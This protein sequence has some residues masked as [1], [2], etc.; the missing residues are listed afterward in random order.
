MGSTGTQF[1]P[2]TAEERRELVERPLPTVRVVGGTRSWGGTSATCW[3][4]EGKGRAYTPNTLETY[5][6]QQTVNVR[7]I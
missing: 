5:Q 6:W 3:F 1:V 2:L 7:D 4:K